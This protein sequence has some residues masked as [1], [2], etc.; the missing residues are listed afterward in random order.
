MLFMGDDGKVPLVPHLNYLVLG[1]EINFQL[2]T[3]VLISVI[4][5]NEP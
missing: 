3:L 4:E 5:I 1:V 2:Q